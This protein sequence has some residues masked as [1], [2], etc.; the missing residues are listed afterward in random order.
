M[1]WRR[2]A[3]LLLLLGAPLVA[4]AQIAA[5]L[6]EGIYEFSPNSMTASNH[7]SFAIVDGFPR[8]RI[9]RYPPDIPK[10]G[11][12]DDDRYSAEVSIAPGT[13][14]YGTGEVAGPLRRN[15]RITE[16][17]NT[18]D[19]NYSEKDP[20]LY[21]SHPWV[22][23]VRK[24]GSAF[25]VLADTTYRCRIDLTK[26]ILFAANGPA[27]PVVIIEGKSPQEVVSRLADLTGH[28]NLPPEWAL[29]YHQCRWSYMSAEE[30][31]Q[32]AREFRKRHIPCDT[33]W[34]DIDYMNGFRVFTFNPQTFPDPAGLN[35][36]LSDLGFHNVWMIDPGVKIDPNYSVYE[37]G[38][39]QNVFVK[40]RL[41]SDQ[42]GNVWPGKTVFPDFTRP[43]TR[44][45]WASLYKP[46][47]AKGITGAWNDMNEPSFFGTSTKTMPEQALHRGGND[48]REG[49]HA[50]YH[51]VYGML[52]ARSTYEGFKDANPNRRPFVLTRA[53]YI[54]YQRYAATWTG[55]NS[56]TWTDLQNV[57]PMV[58]NLGLSGQPFAGPD[59]P[60][61]SGNGPTDPRERIEF[62]SRWWALGSM[63]PFCRGHASKGTVRKEPWAFGPEVEEAARQALWRRY[64]LLPYLYST[65]RESAIDGLPVARPL[66]FSDPK[67]P[68]LRS[69]DRGFLLGGDLAILPQVQPGQHSL[70]FLSD[71]PELHIDGKEKNLPIV[72]IR[73]GAIVPMGKPKEFVDQ[74]T[75]NELWLV[76]CLDASGNAKGSLYEDSGDGYKYKNGGFQLTTF[77]ATLS[78]RSIHFSIKKS[79][80]YS[81]L[82]RLLVAFIKNGRLLTRQVLSNNGT[83]TLPLNGRT[84]PLNDQVLSPTY[85]TPALTRVSGHRF[86]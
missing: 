81:R 42:I 20:S 16:C 83:A 49:S 62:F 86:L 85:Q 8:K 43:Q 65:F 68:K 14:L 64:V 1:N 37:S 66:F 41:G 3:F 52:M 69:V 2:W 29:G 47:L 73:P 58:L 79:G 44:A 38:E 46:W 7:T 77:K 82:H 33:M 34:F 19:F 78:G 11:F 56:S 71:W 6:K 59:I 51:N 30:A 24:D 36:Q 32:I 76:V 75:G 23:A 15:G 53:G 80:K 61:F 40:T 70:D 21:Q 18:D 63:M 50:E 17:W 27:F 4:T 35:K 25:G 67:N 60:G 5:E 84:Y 31:L 39:A 55:D 48:F 13:D 72:K 28:M 26:D 45:W 22:L 10:F 54:G 12:T 9:K 57:I 74:P